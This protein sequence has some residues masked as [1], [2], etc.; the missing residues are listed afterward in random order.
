[1]NFTKS[2]LSLSD[3]NFCK[4]FI[5]LSAYL[6]GPFWVLV[7]CFL[8]VS[9]YRKPLVNSLHFLFWSLEDGWTLMEISHSE[10]IPD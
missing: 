1:M 4:C 8:R 10:D 6:C 9:L 7:F 2:G 3:A 5:M